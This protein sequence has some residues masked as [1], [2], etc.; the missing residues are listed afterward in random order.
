MCQKAHLYGTTQGHESP[1][2]GMESK[3]LRVQGHERQSIL[4]LG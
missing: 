4:D 3:V 1:T 2:G